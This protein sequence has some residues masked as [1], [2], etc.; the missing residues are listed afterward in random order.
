MDLAFTSKRNTVWGSNFR[1]LLRRY[2]KTLLVP[3]LLGLSVSGCKPVVNDFAF[4]PDNVSVIP[5]SELPNGIQEITVTAEDQVKTTSLYL[6]S[7]ASNKLVIYF[8]GNAGNIY[9]RIPSLLTLQKLGV[10]VLGVSYRGYGKSDGSPT[11]QGVYLDG[12]A[13]FQYA[14]EQLGFPRE[15]IIIFGRSIGT[16]VAVNTAQNEQI[17]GLILVSPLTSGRAQAQAAGLGSVASLAGDSFDNLSKV[18]NIE[19]PLLVIHGT[20]DRVIPFSMG[21]EIFDRAN[22]MKVFVKIEGAN[23]NDLEHEF[24]QEYWPPILRFIEDAK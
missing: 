4:H 1:G 22:V 7:S 19:A 16:A 20:D 6:S 11:E 14:V 12:K 8:H 5:T 2:S 21:L 23:H 24:G 15:N 10:S 17:L 13:I 9:H 18:E 3:I